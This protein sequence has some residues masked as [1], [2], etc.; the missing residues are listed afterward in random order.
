MEPKI[1]TTYNFVY[2]REN[3]IKGI[4]KLVDVIRP[5]Y[6]PA[7]SNVILQDNL[8]PY[9]RITNDGKKIADAITLADTVENMGANLVKE[10]ADKAQKE[11]GDGRKTTM[12]LAAAIINK[13]INEKD[14][15]PLQLKKELDQCLPMILK[16]IEDNT[17]TITPKDVAPIAT[18][19]SESEVI[20]NKIGEIYQEIGA[21]GIIEIESSTTPETSYFLSEGY[22]VRNPVISGFS[23]IEFNDETN[24][25]IEVSKATIQNPAIVICRDNISNDKQLEKIIKTCLANKLT[26][27]VLFFDSA[28][29]RVPDILAKLHI[30]RAFKIFAIKAPTLWKE[31]YFEDLAKL[32]GATAINHNTGNTFASFKVENIG[33]CDQVVISKDEARFIG[34][35]DISA[36]IEELKNQNKE[37]NKLRTS[38]LQTKVATLKIGASS[39]SELSYYLPKANDGCSAAYWAL[40]KG[41]VPGAGI[42]LA[43]CASKMPKTTGGKILEVALSTPYSIIS[44]STGEANPKGISDA[45]VV[46]ENAVK[47]AISIA[48]IVLTAHGAI[49]LQK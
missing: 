47:N 13:G 15:T 36:H 2:S 5:T 31:W 19:A 35:K 16:E 14:I 40:Q 42:T 48:G 43:L 4:N 26:N 11:S 23:F 46:I 12:L 10:A 22:R 29:N 45:A 1:D 44:D 37:E 41:I 6:G 34:T 33:T 3:L 8:Y 28:E 30:S 24:Q 27:I 39:E 20:G 38:F 25:A 49:P 32:T 7:G 17:K 21:D 9:H 18:L